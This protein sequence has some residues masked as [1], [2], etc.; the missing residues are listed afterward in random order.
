METHAQGDTSHAE[1]LLTEATGPFSHAEGKSTT[2][3]GDPSHAEGYYT[4]A[5]G[6]ASHAEGRY[7]EASGNYSHAEGDGTKAT[8]PSEHA[9]GRYNV[10][11]GGTTIFS[12]GIG[13]SDDDRKNAFEVHGDGRIFVND[14]GGYTGNG[15]FGHQTLQD[16]INSGSGGGGASDYPYFDSETLDSLADG[17][18]RPLSD[19]ESAGLTEEDITGMASGTYLFLRDDMRSRTYIVQSGSMESNTIVT[20]SYGQKGTNDYVGYNIESDG[21]NCTITKYTSTN[22]LD[23]HDNS[24]HGEIFN[25]FT[26]NKA[27]GTYSHAEGENTEASGANSHAEGHLTRSG[28]HCSHAEGYMTS[29]GAG[30]SH[31]EGTSS[32]AGG[33]NSHAEGHSS[34][35]S[36]NASHAEG[37]YTRAT[38]DYEHAEGSY[39]ASHTGT[40]HS[41]GIGTSGTDRKNAVEVMDDG[42]MFVHGIGGYDG[43]N[44]DGAK[45]LQEAVEAGQGGGSAEAPLHVSA[46]LYKGSNAITATLDRPLGDGEELALF[47]LTRIRKRK[48]LSAG[49]SRDRGGYKYTLLREFS[50]NTKGGDKNLDKK[51]QQFAL[52]RWNRIG[53]N[54]HVLCEGADASD[55]FGYDALM[56]LFL[57]DTTI[58]GNPYVSYRL[59]DGRGHTIDI[60]QN[61]LGDRVTLRMAVGVVKRSTKGYTMCS[62]LA[63]FSIS[64]VVVDVAG[65]TGPIYVLHYGISVR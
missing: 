54:I 65:Q 56:K 44:P 16:V 14:I 15:T 64:A 8:N 11:G 24:S 27:S 36:G 53:E 40:R 4:E 31:A 46:A 19:L 32:T 29:S 38:N 43:T 13:T 57:A 62:N 55:I 23:F 26:N 2:A 10:S 30:F 9:C 63:R 41:I 59:Q 50:E 1:G 22:T 28:G 20:F 61:N 37:H 60:S 18:S 47:R 39:N 42:R 34:R 52:L 51:F 25:D 5:S 6:A 48:D 49:T 21:S 58:G 3:S 45:T 17:E 35:T 7:T 12:I 33:E